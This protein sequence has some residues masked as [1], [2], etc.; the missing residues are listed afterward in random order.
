MASGLRMRTPLTFASKTR[1]TASITVGVS[2]TADHPMR[3]MT[4]ASSVLRLMLALK[5]LGL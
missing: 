2:D 3:A 1:P 4:I 5:A